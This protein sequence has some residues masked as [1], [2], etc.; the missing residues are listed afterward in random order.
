MNP[1]KL[2][3]RRR[4]KSKNCRRRRLKSKNCRRRKKKK[5]KISN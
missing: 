5:N 4:L 2:K 3:N 1:K